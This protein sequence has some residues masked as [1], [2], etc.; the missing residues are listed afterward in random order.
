DRAARDRR[1]AQALASFPALAERLDEPAGNLSGGQQQMLGLAMNLIAAPSLLLIDELSLGLAPVV[2]ER[3]VELVREVAAEGTT[4]ILVEQSVNVALTL[5]DRAYFLEKGQVRFSGPTADLLDRPDLLRSVFL[6]RA[7]EAATSV[8]PAPPA[9][10]AA[11]TAAAA[12]GAAARGTAAAIPVA[13]EAVGVTCTFGGVRA[14]DSVDLRVARGE[15][16]GLI[17]PNGAGKTT[18]LDALCG[19]V[20]IDRGEVCLEGRTITAMS[21]D[22]RAR[23][24]LGRSFQDAALFGSLTVGEALAASLH[25]HVAVHDVFNPILRMPVSVAA[26]A[27]VRSRVDELLDLFALDALADLRVGELSTGSRRI[28]DLAAS[29]ALSPSVL[30]L[31]EPSSGIAQR[32]AEALGPLIRRI[33]DQLGCAVVVVEHD[34]PLLVG[35]A[36]RLVAM[37]SGAVVTTGVAAEVLAHPRVVEAYLGATR[38]IIERSGDRGTEEEVV[39]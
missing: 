18:L 15:I 22:A 21:P 12:D 1:V 39:T 5:A 30:L 17:G 3:L 14:V 13:L 27:W 16:V 25:R 28:V 38:E 36:D 32:E 33:R 26:E 4:V 2:V 31:D 6:G 10:G 29:V 35:I 24:G 11:R 20:S 19:F 7:V 23:R 8:T 34:M 37:E 9:T